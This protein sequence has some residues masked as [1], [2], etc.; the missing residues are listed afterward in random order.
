MKYTIGFVFYNHTKQYPVDGIAL[1]RK[2][3]LVSIY[4]YIKDSKVVE[5]LNKMV[6]TNEYILQSIKLLNT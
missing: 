3:Y 4:A 2:D 5:T 1:E 6:G